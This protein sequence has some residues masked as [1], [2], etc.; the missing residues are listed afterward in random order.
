MRADAGNE[1][2]VTG[3]PPVSNQGFDKPLAPPTS[4]FGKLIKYGA[5]GRVTLR[6]HFAYVYDFII[7]SI[8][9]IMIMYIFMQLWRVTYQ[10]EG[11]ALIEG[12]SYEQIIW[13]I[14]FAE[15][16]T[17]AFPS[18]S[19]KIEEEVKNGDVGY[20]LTRPLSYIGYHYVGYVSEVSIRLLVNV[21][22]G[23]LLGV[24]MFGWPSFG[25]G[26]AG[27]LLVSFGAVTINFLL[28]MVLALC[29]FWV[30]ETR[31]LEFVYHKMLFTIGG[32]LMPLE[33]FPQQLQAVCRWLPFQTVL[34]FPAKTV[35][36]WADVQLLS[37][38][39]TQAAWVAVL[40]AVVGLM[41][42]RGVKKL[43]VNGG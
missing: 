37:M 12:Y 7:R 6:N 31:G 18:L 14:L 22:I 25:W 30:E 38:L 15:A 5:I 33:L 13:Y 34:Y 19:T 24:I 1:S 4:I 9:L 36:R 2:R 32:M 17:T 11:T 28:N 43:N 42:L 23:G 10:G 8:F 20:K 35:V 39:L 29:S 3:G 26:W 40:A 21:C 41:Y 16:L 27:F